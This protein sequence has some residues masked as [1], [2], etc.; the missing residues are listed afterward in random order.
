MFITHILHLL[1]QSELNGEFKITIIYMFALQIT[2]NFKLKKIFILYSL[3]ALLFVPDEV[4]GEIENEDVT[5][6]TVFFFYFSH[7]RKRAPHF[8]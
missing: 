7:G 6:T 3:T 8:C 4:V 5:A 2:L 1:F